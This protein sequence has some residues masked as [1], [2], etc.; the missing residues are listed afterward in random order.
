MALVTFGVRVAGAFLAYLSQ[1]L[2]ARWMGAHDYGIYS[3]AWTW[4]IVLGI[5]ASAGFSTSANR[6]IP[7]YDKAGDHAGL[8]GFLRASYLVSFGVG[9]LIAA[10]GA[11]G[12]WLARDL[13]EP[14]Y[15]APMILILAALPLFSLGNVLDGVA[16]S[17]DWSQLAM[18]PTYIWR[19]LLVLALVG[20]LIVAG[21]PA[22][23]FWAAAVAVAA[24]W[25]VALYQLVVIDRRL[26]P[27][28]T[29][30]TP[31]AEMRLWVAVSFPMFL[32][33]GI[34][35][36]ITSA[37]VIMVSFWQ[38]PHEV[39]IY[40]AASRTLALV[41]FVYFAVRAASAHRYAAFMQDPQPHRLATYVRQ[42][43]H[44][45]FWPSLVVALG[46]LATAPL[47]LRLF[48]SDFASGYPV[49]AVLVLGVL[50][51]ASVGP[52]DA[53]LTMSGHQKACAWIYA[54]T[55]LINVCFNFLLIPMIGLVGA[56][57]ATTLSILFEAFCLALV[58]KRR[59]GLDTFVFHLMRAPAC[60]SVTIDPATAV[61]LENADA[62][63][64]TSM[65]L[66]NDPDGS[67]LKTLVLDPQSLTPAQIEAWEDLAARATTPNPFF[68]PDFVPAL[69][70]GLAP[71]GSR[72]VVV[73]D[74]DGKWLMAAPVGRVK[75]GFLLPSATTLA[76]NYGPFG[77]PLTAP[78]ASADTAR[79]FLDGARRLGP[80]SVVTLPFLPSAS[81]PWRLFHALTSW[82]AEAD[83][84]Q[85]RAAHAAGA[86][87][88]EMTGPQGKKAKELRRQLRRLE[89]LGP[90]R[91]DS[92]EGA[93]AAELFETFLDLESGGWK[94]RRQSAMASRPPLHAFARRMIAGLAAR[95]DL[96]IDTL[97]LADRPIAMMVVLKQG[98]AAF[99]WKI[100]YDE[101]Y[102][103]FS[104]GVHLTLY[105]RDRN[106]ADP[107][108]RAV[109]SLAIPGH[110]MIE[111]LWHGRMTYAL[112]QMEAGALSR[113]YGVALR[114]D[115]A[116]YGLVRSIALKLLNR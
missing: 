42:T 39:G 112:V 37:D 80:C 95:G 48:G 49:L 74:R 10:V 76:T 87:A 116:L 98:H 25:V 57:L 36:L 91:F 53:L 107:A 94:G 18:F 70:N 21:L 60:A 47:L 109:D 8:K 28:M 20:L 23:A 69:L 113:L 30:V 15:V 64:A 85:A 17:Y 6:F 115:R 88:P 100:A 67:G 43:S 46:L 40:F 68:G 108:L 50:A 111:P 1:I 77:A 62:L 102:A 55:F 2:L 33:E 78:G 9:T 114:A 32:V 35:Q 58:A 51:R 83:P 82:R 96:R 5:M 73:T 97:S 81:H 59:L 65:A 13:I 63:H 106:L 29:S 66:A 22:T 14:Y 71:K 79:A 38:D 34:L 44:W 101:D 24:T 41:H 54:A 4:I 90:V 105:T 52:V 89:D 3:L 61:S 19:P 27:R 103:R 86:D 31:R 72:L 56:A 93:E 99:S 75:A 26:R 92:V 7:A 45:T 104:P 11:A 16:R 110:P 84:L 12:V